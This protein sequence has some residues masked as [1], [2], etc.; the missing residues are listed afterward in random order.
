[1][2]TTGLVVQEFDAGCPLPQVATPEGPCGT[3]CD[4]WGWGWGWGWFCNGI[5][6]VEEAFLQ[7]LVG[8]LV[9]TSGMRTTGETIV[10]RTD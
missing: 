1:M 5:G 9:P 6:E 4:M 8:Q 7:D 2:S 3:R 10:L